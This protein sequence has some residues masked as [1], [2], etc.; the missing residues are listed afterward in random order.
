ML[1]VGHISTRGGG[2]S[3]EAG[4]DPPSGLLV[5]EALMEAEE[6]TEPQCCRSLTSGAFSH[7]VRILAFKKKAYWKVCFLLKVFF[8]ECDQATVSKY[9]L[10][11]CVCPFLSTG[12]DAVPYCF[13]SASDIVCSLQ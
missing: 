5:T 2:A 13:L 3:S 1:L 12:A 6:P 7:S 9:E 11:V 4:R 10:Q 8:G